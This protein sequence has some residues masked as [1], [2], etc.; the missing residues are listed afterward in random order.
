MDYTST[1]RIA[2]RGS[3]DFSGKFNTI[4]TNLR[5]NKKTVAIV[6]AAVFVFY[7]FQIRPVQ[8][9]KACTINAGAN[10]RALLRSKAEVATDAARRASYEEL[11]AKNMYLRTDYESYYSK[12]LHSYGIFN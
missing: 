11:I 3:W 1:Q 10:A 7:W 4:V 6:I 9:N 8:I 12:C 5:K 2:R